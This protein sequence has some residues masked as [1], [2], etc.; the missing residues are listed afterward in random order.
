M[1]D[2]HGHNYF[3]AVS[4]TWKENAMAIISQELAE[5]LDKIEEHMA[6]LER[7]IEALLEGQEEEED[8]IHDE[9]A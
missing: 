1:R 5:R 8:A 3:F 7:A 2:I 4:K 9:T 6:A